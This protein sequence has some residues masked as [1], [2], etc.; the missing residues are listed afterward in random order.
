MLLVISF[1]HL[2]KKH[3]Y[4]SRKTT[5]LSIDFKRQHLGFLLGKN[6]S[7]CL[8]LKLNGHVAIVQSGA[9][10]IVSERLK[11]SFSLALSEELALVGKSLA[12]GDEQAFCAPRKNDGVGQFPLCLKEQFCVCTGK[13]VLENLCYL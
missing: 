11:L 6:V 9:V 3:A 10:V 4:V 5:F 13:N 1:L 8:H 12:L 7:L 2:R